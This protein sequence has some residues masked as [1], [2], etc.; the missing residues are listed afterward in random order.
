M[1]KKTG[2]QYPPKKI[3][4]SRDTTFAYPTLNPGGAPEQR[5]PFKPPGH[6]FVPNHGKKGAALEICTA[7]GRTCHLLGPDGTCP[8]EIHLTAIHEIWQDQ[9]HHVG[10]VTHSDNNL[11]NE[12]VGQG[13]F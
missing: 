9:K 3:Y 8:A 10:D 11:Q 6:Y 1:G 7:S 13:C 5:I 12:S 2:R 4:T